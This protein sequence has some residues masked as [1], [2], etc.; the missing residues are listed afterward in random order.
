MPRE[1]VVR[2]QR[3]RLAAATIAMVAEHGY[4]DTTVTGI[5]EAAGVSTRTFYVY[6]S[7]KEQCF[8]ETFDLIVDHLTGEMT[9]AVETADVGWPQG[10]QTRL[11]TMLRALADNPDLI[12]FCFFSLGTEGPVVT[13]HR[14]WMEE[15]LALLVADVPDSEIAG[16]PSSTAE[17]AAAGGL[18]ALLLREARSGDGQSLV[19]LAPALTELVLAPYVG[20]ERAAWAASLSL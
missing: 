15:L 13:R 1:F 20:R 12:Q 7:S 10:V 3:D 19:D 4:H 9:A 11:V 17:Q 16:P 18:S 5:V 14:R 2:N 8:L 6:F